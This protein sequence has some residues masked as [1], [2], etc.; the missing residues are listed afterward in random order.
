MDTK[1]KIQ[2]INERKSLFFEEINKS[3]KPSAKL[4]KRRKRT[5]INKARNGK[6]KIMTNTN[7]IKRIMRKYFKNLYSNNLGTL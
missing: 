7:E 3:N 5:Q 2:R 6:G 1:K 4:T